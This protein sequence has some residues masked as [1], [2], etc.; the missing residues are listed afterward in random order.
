MTNRNEINKIAKHPNWYRNARTCNLVIF[1]SLKFE[2]SATLGAINFL[3]EYS[4]I[5]LINL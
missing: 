5:V 3:L 4:Y 2:K 1:F